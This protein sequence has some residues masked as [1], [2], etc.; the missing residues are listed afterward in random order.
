[1]QIL[2]DIGKADVNIKDHLNSDSL[3]HYAAIGQGNASLYIKYLVEKSAELIHTRVLPDSALVTY[4]EC[5]TEAVS[6]G[7]TPIVNLAVV[8]AVLSR[9]I[10]MPVGDFEGEQKQT[11]LNLDAPTE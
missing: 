1:V 11:L 6:R 10:K 2:C 4:E 8:K 7:G 5:L 3:L 9:D